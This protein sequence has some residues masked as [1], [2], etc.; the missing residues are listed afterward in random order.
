MMVNHIDSIFCLKGLY[1]GLHHS[2]ANIG[3][4]NQPNV[5]LDL[6]QISRHERNI[7]LYPFVDGI[8]IYF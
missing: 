5:G 1:I 3:K 7:F 4:I 6:L 2:Y 8:V